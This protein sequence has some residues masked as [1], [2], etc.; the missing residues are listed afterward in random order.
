MS[1]YVHAMRESRFW[2]MCLQVAWAQPDLSAEEVEFKA[3]L[4]SLGVSPMEI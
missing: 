4:I 2:K 1:H 3:V